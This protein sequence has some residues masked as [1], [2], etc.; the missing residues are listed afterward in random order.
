MNTF[1]K[2]HETLMHEMRLIH[3]PVAIKYF[4]DQAELDS[5]KKTQP[6][7]SPIKPLTFCQ[8]EVA[9]AWKVLQ[10]L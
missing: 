1:E 2:L 10:C 5:F 8:S 9:H 7:Y 3:A 6:H 4:F